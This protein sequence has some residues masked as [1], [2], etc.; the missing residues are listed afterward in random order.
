MNGAAGSGASHS[1]CCPNQATRANVASKAGTEPTAAASELITASSMRSGGT[2]GEIT[3]TWAG[4]PRAAAESRLALNVPTTLSA[5]G[6]GTS[7]ALSV[8]CPGVGVGHG[9]SFSSERR[10]VN[11]QTRRPQLRHVTIV[12]PPRRHRDRRRS[13]QRAASA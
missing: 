11:Q 8:G 2:N 6:I 3:V 5:A 1:T 7:T 12:R 13:G 4:T 10:N 9:A